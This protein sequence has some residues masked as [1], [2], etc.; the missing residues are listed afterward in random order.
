MDISKSFIS[1]KVRFPQF[2]QLFFFLREADWSLVILNLRSHP[3]GTLSL[4]RHHKWT[5][6]AKSNIPQLKKNKINALSL[7]YMQIIWAF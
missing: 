2:S 4:G 3:R 6:H 7:N 1:C 5:K